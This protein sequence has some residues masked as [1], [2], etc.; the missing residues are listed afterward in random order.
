LTGKRPQAEALVL[1]KR[2]LL[3]SLDRGGKS[4]P[5]RPLKGAFLYSAN[6]ISA[7]TEAS[8]PGEIFSLLG[9]ENIAAGLPS[10]Q[11]ILSPEYILARNPDFLFGA[12]SITKASDILNADPV[13]MKTT[14][15]IRGSVTIVPSA[16]FLRPSPRIVDCILELAQSLRLFEEEGDESTN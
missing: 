14:A 4:G 10:E 3:E 7:F 13:I 5:N 15:G 6:P 12:M 1:E 16:Y 9:A 11:P 2:A 8:L